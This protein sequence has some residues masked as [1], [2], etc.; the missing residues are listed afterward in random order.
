MEQAMDEQSIRQQLEHWLANFVEQPNPL[1]NNWP[2]CPYARQ[3]RLSNQI[4]TVFDSPLEIAQYT[5]R[6]EEYDVV[7]LCFDHTRFS[8]SQIEL[9]TQHVNS[10]LMLQDFVVLCDHPDSEEFINGAKMNFGECGLMILQ[11][12]SKLNTAADQLRNKGYYATW[13]NENLDEVVN[14]RYDLCKN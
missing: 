10:M 14:W 13:S 6:L 9:F 5:N 2:P 12:L 11:R 8:A 7:I 4:L 1:L 3:A